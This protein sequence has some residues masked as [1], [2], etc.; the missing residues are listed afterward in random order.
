VNE[1]KEPVHIPGQKVVDDNPRIADEDQPVWLTCNAQAVGKEEKVGLDKA[2]I[3]AAVIQW[4]N[5]HLLAFRKGQKHL[6]NN[7][8]FEK[9]KP[10]ENF[11]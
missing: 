7:Q 5:W 6:K 8:S 9:A 3:S 1:S 11:P 2:Q 10:N 4:K